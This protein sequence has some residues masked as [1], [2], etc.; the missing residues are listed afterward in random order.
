[1]ACVV[2]SAPQ[3]EPDCFGGT[4]HEVVTLEVPRVDGSSP[5][6]HARNSGGGGF[7]KFLDA[8]LL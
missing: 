5:P 2:A 7:I 1:M 3:P 6:P 8:R 4:D